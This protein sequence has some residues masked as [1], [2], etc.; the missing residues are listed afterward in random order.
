M[1]K[2]II[3]LFVVASLAFGYQ[4]SGKSLTVTASEEQWSY[5]FKNMAQIKERVNQS[6]LPHQQVVFVI[7]SLDSLQNLD[8]P[9][10]LKQ[11][12]DSIKAKK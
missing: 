12:T 2:T 8:Y 1:K 9:Q 5:H 7:T 4:Y 3:A 11:L 6:N 10:L